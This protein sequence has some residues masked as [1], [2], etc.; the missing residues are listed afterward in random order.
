[1]PEKRSWD[2][3]LAAA[4]GY[5]PVDDVTSSLS[6]L[7]A[8]DVTATGGKLTKAAKLGI[9][10]LPLEEFL[11]SLSGAPAGDEAEVSQPTLF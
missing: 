6:L 9:R 2:E 10:V 1:M 5:T 7:V 4:T 11:A 8:A 3:K